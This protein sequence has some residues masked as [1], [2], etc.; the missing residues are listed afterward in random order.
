VFFLS[1][2]LVFSSP[3]YVSFLLQAQEGHH[4]VLLTNL[5]GGSNAR[6]LLT[7]LKHPSFTPCERGEDDVGKF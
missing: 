3:S 4:C 2:L 6:S 7:A 1:V 5:R